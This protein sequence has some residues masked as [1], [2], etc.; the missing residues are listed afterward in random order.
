MNRYGLA[1]LAAAVTSII[2]LG[3][4][5]LAQT[6]QPTGPATTQAPAPGQ[7]PRAPA[8]APVQAPR[9]NAA[10]APASP[11]VRRHPTF[12]SCNRA[13]KRRNLRGSQRRSF[14]TRCRLG[15]EPLAR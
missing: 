12:R 11:E 10:P 4:S 2:A 7:A 14:V 9:P 3:S 1:V 13:A 6:P 8:A 15:R 5:A